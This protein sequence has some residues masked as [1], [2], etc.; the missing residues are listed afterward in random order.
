MT[1]SSNAAHSLVAEEIV[2]SYSVLQQFFPFVGESA[3]SANVRSQLVALATTSNVVAIVGDIGTGKTTIAQ[4]LHWQSER[5]A[6]PFVNIDLRQYPHENVITK[7]F[8]GVRNGFLG[9]ESREVGAIERAGK[10]MCVVSGFESLPAV[11]QERCL[12]WLIDGRYQPVG[13][14]AKQMS[15]SRIVLEVR[16]RDHTLQRGVTLIPSVLELLSDR[17]VEV[18]GMSRR[19]DDVLPLAEHFKNRYI[20]EWGLSS[21]EFS[22]EV[23]KFLKRVNWLAGV[24]SIQTAIAKSLCEAQGEPLA[25]K[26]F[27]PALL[28][29]ADMAGAS[30]IEGAALEVLVE[31]KLQHFFSRLG[32]FEVK[33]LYETVVDRVEKPLFLLT[34]L[35]AAGNQLRA[36][37]MLGLNRNTLRS[38]LKKYGL[39]DSKG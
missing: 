28:G 30:G 23:V 24:R 21:E 12:S 33:G 37:R 31:E 5:N 18:Y 20:A 32:D 14:D 17:V 27:P 9:E 19:K 16:S 6:E 39:L 1:T 26:H 11:L 7:L 13:T 36:A 2:T 15:S 35:H 34:M 3:W 25:I 38:R 8:G 10:G 29:R 4:H 22:P